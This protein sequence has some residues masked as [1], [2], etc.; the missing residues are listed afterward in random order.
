MRTNILT[1]CCLLLALSIPI[2]AKKKTP[3][4]QYIF[5]FIGDG[6]GVNQVNATEIF[7][8]QKEGKTGTSPLCFASFPYTGFVTTHSA[9]NGVTDSAASGTA[10]ATGHKTKNGALGLGEEFSDTVQSI[11]WAAKQKGMAVG[12]TTTVGTDHATPAAFYAHVSDR[13]KMS[14]IHAQRAASGYD[15][16]MGGPDGQSLAYRLDRSPSELSQADIVRMA[17][18]SLSRVTSKG[19][20]LMSEGGMIDWAC[21]SNDAAAVIGETLDFDDAIKVAYNFY[22]QHPDETLIVVTADH[23]TGGLVLTRGFYETRPGNLQ[24]Q[25]MTIQ[26]L[27][28]HLNRQRAAMGEAFTWDYVKQFVKENFG[29]GGALPLHK[30]QEERMKLAFDNTEK[31]NG[32]GQKTL[33][34]ED[35]EF[36]T[37]VRILMQ[38]MALVTFAHTCHSAGYVPCYAIGVGAEQFTGRFD[39]T[40]IPKKIARIAGLPLE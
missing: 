3:Q 24:H 1:I 19:F 4:P 9:S 15:F 35:S 38:E 32:K 16:I 28:R 30:N 29:L 22:L 37:C 21:H 5:Y 12:I 7:L 14:L 23:E 6:M 40:D 2:Q 8:G 31:G 26:Q 13:N 27:G 34:Q 18:D 36:C 10:L 17:I 33:Y 20:F 25:K 11:A 39:N